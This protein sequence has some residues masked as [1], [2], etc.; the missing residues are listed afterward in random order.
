MWRNYRQPQK[1]G[2]CMENK[3][4]S[5]FMLIKGC[6]HGYCFKCVGRYVTLKVRNNA[7]AIACPH[8]GCKVGTLTPEM[9]KPVLERDLFDHW[10]NALMKNMFC[11]RRFC[12][13]CNSICRSKLACKDVQQLRQYCLEK[14]DLLLVELAKEKGWKRCPFCGFYVEKV[15]GCPNVLCR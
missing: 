11:G 10:Y 5:D 12:C 4:G 15:S 1:C 9:C 3:S 13:I 7:A 8:P 2:I 6:L 14:E